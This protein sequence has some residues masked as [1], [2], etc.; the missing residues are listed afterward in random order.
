MI[1]ESKEGPV[2]PILPKVIQPPTP[3]QNPEI[4]IQQ[5][6]VPILMEDEDS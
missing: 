6:S 5:Q 3:V 1:E 4:I 2:A